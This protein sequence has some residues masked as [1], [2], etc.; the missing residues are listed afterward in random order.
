MGEAKPLRIELVTSG[1]FTGRGVGSIRIDGTSAI[2][3]GA[4]STELTTEERARL[5]RLPILRNTRSRSNTADAVVYT[6][7][8]DGR[9]WTWRDGAAPPEFANWADA[10]LA[11]R[12]RVLNQAPSS[13]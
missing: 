1:G 10:L 3:D 13:M 2:A 6:L 7:T 8:I 5:D 11:T 9:R 12:A 4:V